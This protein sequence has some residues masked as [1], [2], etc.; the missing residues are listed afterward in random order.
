MAAPGDAGELRAIRARELQRPQRAAGG[1]RDA[2]DAEATGAK[3]SA[4]MC[5]A[6]GE[7]VTEVPVKAD[8]TIGDEW[9]KE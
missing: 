6:G 8:P 1:L 7:F 9:I 4:A 5:A 2:G 3:V